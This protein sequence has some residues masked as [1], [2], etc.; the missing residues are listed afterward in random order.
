MRFFCL[1]NKWNNMSSVCGLAPSCYF[2]G[3]F[4]L[5]IAVFV[6]VILSF[7]MFSPAQ[8]SIYTYKLFFLLFLGCMCFL[9]S[10]ILL[11]NLFFTLINLP[12]CKAWTTHLKELCMRRGCGLVWGAE[13]EEYAYV[14]SSCMLSSKTRS[15]VYDLAFCM[16]WFE[17]SWVLG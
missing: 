1:L 10:F 11:I 3:S 14:W 9:F 17:A 7:L 12:G 2:H 4:S 16:L 6:N 13:L 5:I 8:L 15:E